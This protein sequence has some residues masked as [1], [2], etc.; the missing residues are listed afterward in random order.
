M[1]KLSTQIFN[2]LVEEYQKS[3]E[4]DSWTASDSELTRDLLGAARFVQQC[5]LAWNNDSLL[6]KATRVA[7][8]IEEHIEAEWQLEMQQQDAFIDDLREMDA[9]QERIKS[10]C[11]FHFY[12]EPKFVADMSRYHA[13]AAEITDQVTD[14]GVYQSIIKYIDEKRVLDK[15]YVEVKRMMVSEAGSHEPGWEP[16]LSV[17]TAAFND[18]LKDVYRRADKTVADRIANAIKPRSKSAE[19]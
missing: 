13:M 12:K 3:K 11:S 16:S 6:G 5:A 1:D 19:K 17:I 4:V 15:I 14:H 9:T 7:A 8:E 2:A 18:A 10:V